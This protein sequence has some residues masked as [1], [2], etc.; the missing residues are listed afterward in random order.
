MI[1]PVV[2]PGLVGEIALPG[3]VS[4]WDPGAPAGPTEQSVC[5][6]PERS[7]AEFS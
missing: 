4:P 3:R 2:L 1:P 6:E 7:A 5:Q